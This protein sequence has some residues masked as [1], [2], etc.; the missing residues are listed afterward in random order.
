MTKRLRGKSGEAVMLVVMGVMLV[1]GLVV[2]M[3]RGD[4]HI[5]PMHGSGHSHTKAG[6]ASSAHDTHG[7]RRP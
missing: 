2:W 3:M 5:M 7:T 4:F 6:A 1:G